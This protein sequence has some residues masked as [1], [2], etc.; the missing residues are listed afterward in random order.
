MSNPDW[1]RPNGAASRFKSPSSWEVTWST[2]IWSRVSIMRCCKRFAAKSSP[3]S[4]SRKMRWK[5]WLTCRPRKLRRF[6]KRLRPSSRPSARRNRSRMKSSSAPRWER[7]SF[8]RWR[9]R[10]PAMW[11]ATKCSPRAGWPTTSSWRMRTPKRTSR[12]R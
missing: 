12:R 7:T 8:A 10:G 3:K 2:P 6:R 5:S 9:C 4:T 11:S 1:T